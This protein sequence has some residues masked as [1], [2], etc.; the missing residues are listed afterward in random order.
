MTKH[1]QKP[2]A[3]PAPDAPVLTAKECAA[4]SGDS[5]EVVRKAIKRGWLRATAPGGQRVGN[6]ITREAYNAWR[7]PDTTAPLLNVHAAATLARLSTDHVDAAITAGE[8]AFADPDR[9][10]IARTDVMQW[11]GAPEAAPVK[12][13]ADDE[14]DLDEEEVA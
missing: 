12:L 4:L 11:L 7:L 9:E 14:E 5:Y 13:G 2:T 10:L 3:L 8:L 1:K 6:R